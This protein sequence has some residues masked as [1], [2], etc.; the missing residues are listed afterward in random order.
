MK[1]AL[2]LVFIVVSANA[3]AQ[4]VPKEVTDKSTSVKKLPMPPPQVSGAGQQYNNLRD[5]LQIQANEIK[6]LS[7][8]I[9]S[10][11]QQMRRMEG[12]RRY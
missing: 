6:S 9:D 12:R 10:L 3:I 2:I 7:N 1:F 8:K 4:Q 11:E 5:T